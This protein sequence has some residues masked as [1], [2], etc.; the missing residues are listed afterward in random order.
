M[1]RHG[2]ARTCPNSRRLLVDRIRDQSWPVG[3]AAEAAG[4]S[5]R[6]AY[7]W[8]RRWREEGVEGLRDHSSALATPNVGWERVAPRALTSAVAADYVVQTAG[9]Y[10]VPKCGEG[11]GRPVD[12]PIEAVAGVANKPV[13][14]VWATAWPARPGGAW[15]VLE[16]DEVRSVVVDALAI[17]NA[18]RAGKAELT[19][20][21]GEEGT[22][23]VG[24]TT[25]ACGIKRQCEAGSIRM[26]AWV[27]VS[28]GPDDDLRATIDGSDAGAAHTARSQEVELGVCIRD[29]VARG[30][31]DAQPRR[32][33]RGRARDTK[34]SLASHHRHRSRRGDADGYVC[35]RAEH[36]Y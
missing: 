27:A 4:V 11:A 29:E 12:L 22:S 35:A 30:S 32:R 25:H 34:L 9:T 10:R 24:L 8:L 20:E 26:E 3:A 6:T 23:L 13:S 17:W 1:K 18:A 16:E 5:E 15:E 21:A 31:G 28:L 14:R 7:R 19:S 2:N 36:T 33:A